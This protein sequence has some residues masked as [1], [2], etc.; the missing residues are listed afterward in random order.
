M[1]NFN[2]HKNNK[3]QRNEKETRRREYKK[4]NIKYKKHKRK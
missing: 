2:L 4:L 1:D 3:E